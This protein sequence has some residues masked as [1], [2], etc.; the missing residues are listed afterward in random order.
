MSQTCKDII[1]FV[2]ILDSEYPGSKVSIAKKHN[3]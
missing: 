3:K 2:N 1:S